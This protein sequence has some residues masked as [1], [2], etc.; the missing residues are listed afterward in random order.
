MTILDDP[1]KP[2]T[3]MIQGTG[4]SEISRC[5]RKTEE[6]GEIGAPEKVESLEHLDGLEGLG[7]IQFRLRWWEVV[8][9]FSHSLT[10]QF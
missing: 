9:N 4:E 1:N 2:K 5:S 8:S 6:A 3:Q 10:N 7:G